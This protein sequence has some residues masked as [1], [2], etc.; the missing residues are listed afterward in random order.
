MSWAPTK[1]RRAFW[2]TRSSTTEFSSVSPSPEPD[3][4]CSHTSASA[5]SSST[6]S[7]RRCRAAPEASEIAVRTIGASTRTPRGTYTNAPPVHPA[8]FKAVKTSWP[9]STTV[10]RC[11]ST[12]SVWLS[13]AS[14]SGSTSRPSSTPP[15]S[16][17]PSTWPR[18][19]APSGASSSVSPRSTAEASPSPG[20]A[21]V[22]A[23]RSSFARSV[24]SHPA[25]PLKRGRSSSAALRAASLRRAFS[26]PG[27]RTAASSAN[28]A[29]HL[30][31]D[32]AV[33][34]HRVLHRELLDDRLDEA[35]DDQLAG[36]GLRDAA[37]HQ[38][39]E[40]LLADLRDGRLVANVHVVLADADRRVG[41]RARLLVEQ[42]RVAD[43]LRA[44]A[45]GALGDLQH[46]AVRGAPAVLGDRLGED[47]RRRVRRDV[48]DLGAGVLVL[49]VARERDRQDLAVGALAHQVD[50]RVLHRELGAEVAVDPLDGRVLPR[51][52][53]LGDE[54][55]DVLR[56]VL[57]GRVA[58]P[59]TRLGDQ[60]DDG[61]VQGV[62]RVDGRRA[63]LDVVHVGALVGDDQRP[64]ELAHVLGVDP[65]VGLQRH[66]DV[67]ARRHVD[68]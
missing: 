2:P 21:A 59:G 15:S 49:A 64:L 38:V 58:D 39:E 46:A 68:E 22:K 16:T 41:V 65:E 6:T 19:M 11:C 37:R 10:P 23:A 28:G 20:A 33:H 31:L 7:T 1:R 12:S 47:V 30:E 53:A 57:H 43:D 34:L 60:L 18:W 29:L 61:G 67:H 56:P 17:R 13:Q 52:R 26:Q 3:R 45:V 63:A 9:A 42:Q 35:V 54:V 32:E 14:V 36:L 48:E 62:R 25:R 40:L 5:P 55:V 51:L 8:S 66:L 4:G 24:N 50:A 27:S 44:R